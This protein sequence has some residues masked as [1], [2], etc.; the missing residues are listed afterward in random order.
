MTR[1]SLIAILILMF[2]GSAF[3][4]GYPSKTPL[5]VSD[6]IEV[7]LDSG[8]EITIVDSGGDTL[9][10]DRRTGSAIIQ[11]TEHHMIHEGKHF[12]VCDYQ[13]GIGDGS[14]FAF[15]VNTSWKELHMVFEVD[16]SGI[17]T[18]DVREGSTVSG[19]TQVWPWNNKRTSSVTS[20]ADFY[21][22]P[23]ED[24]VGATLSRSTVGAARRVGGNSDRSK[25]LILGLTTTYV[26]ELGSGTAS[27]RISYCGEWYEVE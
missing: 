12:F 8:A 1:I 27:N 26:F 14:S 23:S 5:S 13:T 7:S 4:S 3:A 24:V 6:S 15:A 22:N 16:G 9:D 18:M 21:F 10:V 17:T 20:T 2:A 25:E 11:E 19:G